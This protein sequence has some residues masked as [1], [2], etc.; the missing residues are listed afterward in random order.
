MIW[1]PSSTDIGKYFTSTKSSPLTCY[2]YLHVSPYRQNVQ[3]VQIPRGELIAFD[4]ILTLVLNYILVGSKAMFTDMKGSTH[5]W[6]Y[7]QIVRSTGVDQ[8]SH[9]LIESKQKM[10]DNDPAVL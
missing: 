9:L 4:W 7:A 10:D 1:P 8:V 3:S 2:G 5:E 6:I